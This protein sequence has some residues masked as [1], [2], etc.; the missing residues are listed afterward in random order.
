MKNLITFSV[1]KAITVFMVIIAVMI[2]GVVSFTRLTT[3]LFPS[4]SAPFAVVVTPYPGATPEDVENNVTIPL[5][6]AF[7]TT[8]NILN[9]QTTSS[10]NLSL[11]TL[12]FSPSTNMDSAVAEMRESLNAL[13]TSLPD[14]VGYP[15]IIQL[16]PNQLPVYTYS[17][18]IEGYDLETLTEWVD[19]V[20]RPQ[21]ERVPGVATFD[22]TG[23]YEQEIRVR[24]DEDAM[25]A[26]NTALDNAF[27][28]LPQAPEFTLDQTYISNIIQAQ[29]VAFPA[30]F[31]EIDGLSYLVRVG[32]DI[33]GI[34]TLEDLVL[35]D[36]QVPGSNLEPITLGDVADVGFE[37]SVGQQYSK[38]NGA[39]AITI[40]IQK[41]SEFAV[42]E[43][44]N[45][46]LDT[47]N[48]LE[49]TYSSLEV[50]T[51]LNQGDVIEEST[52]GV[53]SNLLLG[54]ILAIIVLLVFLRNIRTTFVVGIAIPVSLTF[55]IILIYLSGITLN[56]VSL[57]GLA[58]GIGMLVDNSIVVI[59]NIFRYKREGKSNKEAAIQ[60]TSQVAGAI[61]AST[62]TTVGVFAPIIFIEDFI[63]EIFLQLAL[64]IAF[65]LVASLII[66]LTFVPAIANQVIRVPKDENAGVTKSY[67][68]VYRSI[69]GGF[70]RVKGL[71]Y[72]VVLGLFG[73]AVVGS[74][75]NG[76][77]FFPSTDEGTLSGTVSVPEDEA[78]DFAAFTAN[79]DEIY[80]DIIALDAVDSIGITLGGGGFG[81][82][83][84]ADSASASLN[85]VLTEDRAK[86][87]AEYR[88]DVAAILAD[89]SDLETDIQGTENSTAFLVGSGAEVVI[90]GP[91]LAT[92]RT[93]AQD[94]TDLMSDIEG[95]RDVDSGLGRTSQEISVTVDKDAAIQYNLTVAQV[96]GIIQ[97]Q[98]ATPE[99]V[100]TLSLAGDLFSVRIFQEGETA[101]AEAETIESFETIVVT[102]DGTGNPVFLSDIAQV[103]EVPG[104]A[105]ISRING[106]RSVTVT[107][108]VE[109]DF[110][111]SLL[112]EDAQSV[113]DDYE[114]PEGYA[115]TLQGESEEISEAVNTLLLA[116]ALGI[117]I[118]YMIM[119]SQFQSL[120]YPFIIMI[121]IPLAFT[122]GLGIL[123]IFDTPVSVV[124]LLGLI[125]LAGVIVNNGIVLVDYIN[126]LRDEGYEL[127]E[128]T[129]KAGETR[130]R[131]IFM[132]A[133]TTIL[134]LTGL[135]AG[136]GDGTELTQPL[137]LTSIGGLIYGTFLTIFV[138]PL[139]YDSVSRHGL[140][141]LLTFLGLVT[142]GAA[143]FAWTNDIL[144]PIWIGL[145]G[146]GIGITLGVIGFT[147]WRLKRTP[148]NA[149]KGPKK[150]PEDPPFIAT[151]FET[152]LDE[153]GEIRD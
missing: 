106:T 139:M 144:E 103:E 70:Y 133:L 61:T 1:E 58:L 22:V 23:A 153:A 96:Y 132:T 82:L 52:N 53:L 147:F 55:A 9:V 12:E 27:S 83:S 150:T 107:A 135:A 60:G 119:A 14:E 54:G 13:E 129:L 56:V 91:D 45:E 77:E 50:T 111:A 116:A 94:V 81:P 134:A 20:M 113:L 41:G 110:N 31:V 18:A 145:I 149:A 43:V 29:N 112:A 15:N 78:F 51:L 26:Y 4:I 65:S 88:D 86:S 62:L 152:A 97:D 148:L 121:T 109:T 47:L 101:N 90:Q 143:G 39:D 114:A 151:D 138:V 34:S 74:V 36:F 126:Q 131:P 95:Y 122:G 71:V 19:E 8:T 2:F 64:T 67:Q 7:Q 100:T 92:L 35:A 57:G 37:D 17:V 44:T 5:E 28:T 10:E 115:I 63:R 140:R 104:F 127:K 3:D 72:I 85:I 32:D 69:L 105:S 123:Y 24:L 120:K 137:A 128:A 38:V 80:E 87:T 76:F 146:G 68:K 21:V 75:S 16:N 40:S 42:T 141:I 59:E 124:A 79:L 66:A 30:G 73:L 49:E 136:I 142:L 48:D 125:V 25:A 118:V 6:N 11:V 102:V 33:D 99:E 130:L 46:V 93:I 89:Y 117:V 108:E 84:G 98:L